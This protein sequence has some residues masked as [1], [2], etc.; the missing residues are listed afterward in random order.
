LRWCQK[1]YPA[2][3][4]VSQVRRWIDSATKSDGHQHQIWRR[5]RVGLKSQDHQKF[6]FAFEKS[7][8]A[9]TVF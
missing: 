1:K 3:N 5:S 4:Y 6:K 8:K 9:A 2:W 7:K